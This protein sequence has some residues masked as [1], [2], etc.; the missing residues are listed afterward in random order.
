[1]YKNLKFKHLN[2][3]DGVIG[4]LCF[5]GILKIGGFAFVKLNLI[6]LTIIME[7]QANIF[8]KLI[9]ILCFNSAF[10]LFNINQMK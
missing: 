4:M 1:M 6:I 2:G 10:L 3:L 5:V 9:L 7:K 8:A